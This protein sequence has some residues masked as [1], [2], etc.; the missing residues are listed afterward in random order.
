MG[1]SL[2]VGIN[3]EGCIASLMGPLRPS[4]FLYSDGR[5]SNNLQTD[6]LANSGLYNPYYSILP[7]DTGNDTTLGG[8]DGPVEGHFAPLFTDGPRP[9]RPIFLMDQTTGEQAVRVGGGD[10]PTEG[11]NR[12][13]L[14]QDEQTVVFLALTVITN[15]Q[16]GFMTS[17]RWPSG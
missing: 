12:Y 5:V 11:Q 14:V 16:Q 15:S 17:P 9:S 2:E 10:G 8:R 6:G 13:R 1:I 7:G 3:D 4:I